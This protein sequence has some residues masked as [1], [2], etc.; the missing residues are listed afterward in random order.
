[1]HRP[2]PRAARSQRP[3]ST[4]GS[5]NRLPKLAPPVIALWS[6]VLGAV[7][8]SR[9]LLKNAALVDARTRERLL[10][11]FGAH[12]IGHDRI[13]LPRRLAASADARRVWRRR[14]RSRSVSL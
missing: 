12:G 8:G 2:S 11:L 5:F 6:R 4:F 10:A 13:E 9:L 3:T 1:M 14:H 7:P